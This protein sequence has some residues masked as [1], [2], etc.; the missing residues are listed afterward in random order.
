MIFKDILQDKGAKLSLEIDRLLGHALKNQK[1]VGNLLLLYVNGFFQEDILAW[2]KHRDEKLNPHVIGPGSEGHS[3]HAHYDFIHKYRTTHIHPM[4]HAEYVKQFVMEKWDKEI[5]DRNTVLIETEETTIQLEMLIYLKFW[6]ADMII[7]KLYQFVRILQGQDYDWYF[8]IA[9]SARGENATGNRQDIVRLKIR[10][11]L[12]DISPLLYDLIKETYKTQIRNSIA[13][14]NYSFLNRVIG[15]NNFIEKD[16]ASQLKRISFDEWIS[17]FHNTLVLHNEYISMNNAINVHYGKIAMENG[18]VV[19]VLI[20]E[21]DGKQYEM[22]LEYR[23]T[24]KD[25]HYRQR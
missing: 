8:K 11:Q 7:K 24:Y 10:D 4:K 5:S 14:S 25:W 20:T 2:H 15:L 6:E 12:K 1:H 17:I 13:H 3:E 16:P 23:D 22:L 9:N 19:P 21:K 18:M